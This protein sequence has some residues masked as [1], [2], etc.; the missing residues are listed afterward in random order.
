M[1]VIVAAA[2]AQIDE[3]LREWDELKAGAQYDDCSDKPESVRQ[4]VA[5]RLASTLHR[6]SPRGSFHERSLQDILKKGGYV[7]FTLPMLAGALLA[8]KREYE[9]GHVE[10]FQELVH[11][12]MFASFMEMAEYLLDQKFKDP[13][14][15]LIGSILEQHLREL[16]IKNAINTEINEKIKR[17]EQLNSDLSGANIYSKLDQKNVTSWLGLRNEAAHGNYAKYTIEQVSLMIDAVRDFM[18]RNPA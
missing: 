11:A 9:L 4:M 7:G 2:V 6:L 14:A 17:A 18:A 13:A 16:C 12:E 1:V 15:V 3:A 5:S 10:T 8:L